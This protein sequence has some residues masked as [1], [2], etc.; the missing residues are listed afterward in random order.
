LPN[1]L[2]AD[3]SITLEI[4]VVHVHALRMYPTEITQ[5]ERQLVLYKTDVYYYSCYKTQTQK[6]IVTLPTDRAESYTQ[7]PKPVSKNDQVITYGA[8]QNVA[9]FSRAELSLHY[10]NNNPFLTVRTLQRW[11]EVSHWGN[12]AV[13]ETVDM[14]HSGAKL[15]GPF[16]RFD[17]QRRQDSYSAVKS[18]KVTKGDEGGVDGFS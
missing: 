5:G 8:Y 1:D 4:E 17:F 3:Q 2:R 16:S 11:I 7:T 12:I 14:Y 10:E 18:F 9:P 6:T 13:E 15:S